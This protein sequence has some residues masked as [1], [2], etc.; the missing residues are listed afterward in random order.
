MENKTIGWLS[1]IA[2]V[3]GG[4]LLSPNITGNAIVGLGESISNMSGAVLVV[5]GLI[6]VYRWNKCKG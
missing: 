2:L 4:F 6:G 3:V 5:L 1:L